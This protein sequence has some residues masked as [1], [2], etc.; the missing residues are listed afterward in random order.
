M[1]IKNENEDLCCKLEMQKEKIEELVKDNKNLKLS[2]QKL[3]KELV[4]LK[5][6]SLSQKKQILNLEKD[7]E[8]SNKLFIKEKDILKKELNDLKFRQSN[9][10]EIKIVK[11]KLR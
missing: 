4:E 5:N 7:K 6:I 11:R 9:T 3:G 2:T 10:I 8:N 1:Q